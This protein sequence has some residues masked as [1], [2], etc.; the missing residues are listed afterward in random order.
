MDDFI[1]WL[2]STVVA[3]GIVFGV[4][5]GFANVFEASDHNSCHERGDLVQVQ[6]T[7]R[8]WDGCYVKRSGTW[9]PFDI[10]KYNRDNGITK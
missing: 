2:V 9:V 1:E 6:V 7:Y 3:A 5:F 4:I 10:W 8:K